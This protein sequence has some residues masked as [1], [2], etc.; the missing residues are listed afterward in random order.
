MRRPFIEGLAA[1]AACTA[2]S[3]AGASVA[4]RIAVSDFR[5]GLAAL[6]PG[7]T[8]AVSF[9]S[10]LGSTSES[11]CSSGMP[12]TDQ[13]LS[14]TSG[15]AFGQARTTTSADPFAGGAAAIAGNVFEAGAFIQTSAY[16]SSLVAQSSGAATIG[17]VNDVSTASFALAPW[18]A[19]TISATVRATASSTG[20]SKFELADSGLLMAIGDA[21]G[22]GPQF[23]YVNF[24]AFAF[25]GL[26]A[27]DDTETAVV[28]LSY[29][30]ESNAAIFGVFSGYVSS[31]ASSGLPVSTVPEP[32]EAAMLVAGLLAVGAAARRR[33][34]D[35][36][37][38][39]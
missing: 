29:V 38:A 4:T 11:D 27:V 17:L 5:V 22:T 39:Q 35:F 8:P 10:L 21:Q 19:M 18:T 31:F 13:R 7:V 12:S 30:N 16:A 1:A 24:N 9:S 28:S 26:G 3:S 37:A 33:R 25:G 36:P 20:A 23:S 2:M 32:A 34:D 6:A 14:F 15:R